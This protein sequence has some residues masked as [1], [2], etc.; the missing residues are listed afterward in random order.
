M[1]LT[2]VALGLQV[3]LGR[4]R[5]KQEPFERPICRWCEPD[6]REGSDAE[7]LVARNRERPSASVGPLRHLNTSGGPHALR[8]EVGRS[9]E[10][11]AV[12]VEPLQVVAGQPRLETL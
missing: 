3:V 9:L 12:A 5:L 6:L 4:Q 11:V 8:L 7:S 2:G 10:V 1:A